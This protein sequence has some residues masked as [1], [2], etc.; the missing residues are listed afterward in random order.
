M[1]YREALAY[2]ANDV[3]LH[4][5]LGAALARLGRMNEARNELETAVRLNPNFEPAQKL[6]AAIQR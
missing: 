6:L 2:R 5:S 3:E 4:T 1:H